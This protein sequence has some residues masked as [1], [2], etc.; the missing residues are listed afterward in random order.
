MYT[1][2]FIL[3]QICCLCCATAMPARAAVVSTTDYFSSTAG[4][5]ATDPVLAALARE[6]VRAQ[7]QALG[8]APEAAMERV[9]ALSPGELALLSERIDELPAGGSILGLVGAVFIVLL[10]LEVVGVTDVFNAI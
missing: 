4:A 2:L 7:L 5:A 3:L 6:D 1:R 10:I 8:V 9:A